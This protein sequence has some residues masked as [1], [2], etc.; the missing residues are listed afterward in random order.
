MQKMIFIINTLSVRYP[1]LF[2][3]IFHPDFNPHYILTKIIQ[4]HPQPDIHVYLLLHFTV[5]VIEK[6]QMKQR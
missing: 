6:Y 5:Q 2:Y 4:I 3:S 1:Y